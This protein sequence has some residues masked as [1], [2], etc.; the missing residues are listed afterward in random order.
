MA[1]NMTGDG[2]DCHRVGHT[3]GAGTRRP[4]RPV[5]HVRDSDF[6]EGPDHPVMAM[7]IGQL[8]TTA[9]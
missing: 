7:A 5:H 8:A 4:G 6:A 3:P 1:T 9:A 2:H